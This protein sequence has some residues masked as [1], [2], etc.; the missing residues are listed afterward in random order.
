VEASSPTTPNERGDA[1]WRIATYAREGPGRAGRRALARQVARLHLQVTGQPGWRH[2]ATYTDQPRSDERPGLLR[3]L[4]DAEGCF[5][6]VVVDSYAR[7]SP[8]RRQLSS[9]LEQL[10]WDG[11]NVVVFGPSAGRRLARLVA[12]LALADLIGE[13]A[14]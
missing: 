7:L 14:R 4:A 3:L 9:I 5:D 8:N 6:L 12:N 2:V 13:A 1:M 11:V 10:R